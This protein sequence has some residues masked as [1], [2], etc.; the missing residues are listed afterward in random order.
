MLPDASHNQQAPQVPLTNATPPLQA[1][2][3]APNTPRAPQL[4]EQVDAQARQ[5]VAQYQQNPY[6][7]AAAFQQLKAQYLTDQFHIK[8]NSAEN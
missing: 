8:P 3:S 2:S 6:A 7:L 4:S 5:L 1:M